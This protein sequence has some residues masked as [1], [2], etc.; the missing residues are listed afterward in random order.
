MTKITLLEQLKKFSEEH[1]GD[2]L[3]PVQ[4]QEED[5]EPPADRPATVYTPCLPELRSYARKAPFATHEIVTSKDAM[6]QRPGGGKFIQSTA[7]VRTRFCVYHE[8][9]REGKLALLNLMERTRIA[10]LEEVVIGGQ[11]KLDLDAGVETL[12][13]PGNPNQ[14]AVSPFYLG[15]MI[16]TWHL[17]IIERKVPY[18][19]K[20]CS[21]IRESGPGPGCDRTDP[22]AAHGFCGQ[23]IDREE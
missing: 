14:T 17:P 3:L 23:H 16:T 21:N 8:N 13:Y 12:V 18:G 10:L 9:E 22:G 4:P 2:L 19:K 15:E 6:F 20:G 7:V 1:T 5:M 11:F